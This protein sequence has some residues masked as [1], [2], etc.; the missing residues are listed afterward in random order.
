M[1]KPYLTVAEVAEELCISTGTVYAM[2]ADA[3]LPSLRV[4]GSIRIS[5]ADLDAYVARNYRNHGSARPAVTAEGARA[6][7]SPGCDG[8]RAC[9]PPP[10]PSAL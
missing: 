6:E 8:E 2:V 9:T 4:R 1:T 10:R 3:E 5:Q 7:S